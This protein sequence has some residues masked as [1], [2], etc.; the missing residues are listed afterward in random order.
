VIMLGLAV[1]QLLEEDIVQ[2]CFKGKNMMRSITNIHKTP[3]DQTE[4]YT[5]LYERL[6]HRKDEELRLNL[7]CF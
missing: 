4:L 1:S 2:L 5:C 3:P 6:I 7:K